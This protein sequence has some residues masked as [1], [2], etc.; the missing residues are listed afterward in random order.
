M[1]E[2]GVEVSRRALAGAAGLIGLGAGVSTAEAAASAPNG[3]G[4]LRP[5]PIDLADRETALAC[6]ARVKSDLSGRPRFGVFEG[7]AI[8]VALGGG[9]RPFV[10]IRGVSVARLIRLGGGGLEIAQ[11]EAAIYCDLVTGRPVQAFAN[12]LNGRGVI[13]PFVFGAFSTHISAGEAPPAWRIAGGHVSLDEGPHAVGER[14][15]GSEP[16]QEDR[17]LNVRR[18]TQASTYHV[19]LA[20]LADANSPMAPSHGEWLRTGPWPGW[21]GMSDAVG[22]CLYRCRHRSGLARLDDLPGRAWRQLRDH[23]FRPDTLWRDL[24]TFT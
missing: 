22:V 4:K 21:L 2:H 9:M 6:L 19:Q 10:G 11:R 3:P 17:A 24:T 1:S 13:A 16:R 23:P 18:A 12:P 8:A 20:D 15:H 7:Q 14:E 5:F